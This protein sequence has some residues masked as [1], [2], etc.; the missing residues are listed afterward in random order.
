MHGLGITSARRRSESCLYFVPP[1]NTQCVPP[2]RSELAPQ[3]KAAA[4]GC[5]V[6]ADADSAARPPCAKPSIGL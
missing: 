6:A 5:T 2:E 4:D 3:R 1:L